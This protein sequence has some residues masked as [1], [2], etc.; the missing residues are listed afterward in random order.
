M[1][2]DWELSGPAQSC[3]QFSQPVL[4]PMEA[5]SRSMQ[6]S[7]SL[8]DVDLWFLMLDNLQGV[9]VYCL[10]FLRLDFQDKVPEGFVS[11]KG[12]SRLREGK[13]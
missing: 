10:W 11:D 3:S 4:V 13:Q 6:L 5:T 8:S 7:V 1:W 12:H 2:T 9:G